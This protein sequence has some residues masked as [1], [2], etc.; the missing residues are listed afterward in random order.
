MPTIAASRVDEYMQLLDAAR[1]RGAKAE[2]RFHAALR[3][4]APLKAEVARGKCRPG[5]LEQFEKARLEVKAADE[6]LKAA[7]DEV[8]RLDS[9]L[10]NEHAR[11]TCQLK[12]GGAP[13]KT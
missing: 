8:R 4:W 5:L 10:A 11:W 2:T 13:A 6:A 7:V 9:E 12:T 1:K 3:S